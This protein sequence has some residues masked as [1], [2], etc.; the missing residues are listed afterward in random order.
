MAKL[1]VTIFLLAGLLPTV[2][3]SKLANKTIR[4]RSKRQLNPLIPNS[5][6]HYP[7]ISQ[8][9]IDKCPRNEVLF[10]DGNCYQLLTQG[11]CA[12][13]EYL[14][15][16]PSNN[17][18]YCV[19]RLCFPDR[20]FVF[21]DQLCHD[22]RTTTVCPPGRE[23]YETMYGTPICQCPD[24]TYEG[25]DD[26]DDDVCEPLL[27][28]TPSCPPGQIFWFK[29]FSLP[30]ECLPDPCGG[31]NLN[32]GPNDQPFV[33]FSDGRCFQL[34]TMPN[35]CPAQTWYSIA[36]ERLQGVCSTLEE[37]GYQVFDPDTLNRLIEIYGPPIARD[38][39]APIPA[40]PGRTPSVGGT[41]TTGGLGVGTSPGGSFN[42]VINGGLTAGGIIDNNQRP[43]AIRPGSPVALGGRP[44]LL[45]TSG[46]QGL[47]TQ[48]VSSQAGIQGQKFHSGNQGAVSPG[49]ITG[50]SVTS[51][52]GIGSGLG[53]SQGISSIPAQ[54]FVTGS[55]GTFGEGVGP[56]SKVPFNQLGSP[57]GVSGPVPGISGRPGLQT[58]RFVT[59]SQGTFGQGV[60]IGSQA[61][62]SQ[63]LHG[64]GTFS[65]SSA[66]HGSFDRG[67]VSQ[68]TGILGI[69][70][71]TD[72]EINLQRGYS[73]PGFSPRPTHPFREVAGTMKT[74]PGS[75]PSLAINQGQASALII[76]DQSFERPGMYGDD[77][78]SDIHTENFD[79]S[80]IVGDVR[81]L[82][83][84][85]AQLIA[86]IDTSSH[87]RPRELGGPVGDLS[88]LQAPRD[89]KLHGFFNS[90]RELV[91]H[92]PHNRSR[93]APQPH[94]AP[95][96]VFETRLVGCRAG[97]ARDVNAKCRDTILPARTPASRP[98]RAA[99]PV[100]PRQGC[101]NGEAFNIQRMCE[102][103]GN[104]VN[105]V[106]AFNLGK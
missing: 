95:G 87:A 1:A 65:G 14:V 52:Q 45:S 100:P 37:A 53:I 3:D 86:N 54:K 2:L 99:P 47:L 11:P 80:S 30:P 35:V 40:S 89:H 42:N 34:G 94:A 106:N 41:V 55:P 50:S 82:D 60:G 27:G 75:S 10:G 49:V 84:Q 51:G 39:T 59:G 17:G 33:P 4:S 16:N 38:S 5:I 102:A 21:S 79:I 32:R 96:N 63:G 18:P 26:L 101:P 92:G 48:G 83:I 28:Q 93:R 72:T 12:I 56:G 66:G 19:E 29:D 103:S 13:H 90:V 67:S 9:P 23:L 76:S 44:A 74:Y 98:S 57:S 68:G 81:D 58:H 36:L 73:T 104:A 7:G 78:V 15:L 8:P 77:D 22:P 64:Q 105:S 97:A 71:G 43:G 46:N 70:R 20:I 6:A 24:G 25:D 61:T 31:D 62:F 85:K 91:H 69:H 88:L